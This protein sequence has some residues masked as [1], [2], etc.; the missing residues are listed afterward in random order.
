MQ[1]I[2]P[3]QVSPIKLPVG[4]TGTSEIKTQNNGACKLVISGTNTEGGFDIS[5][6]VK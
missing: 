3:G 5:W 4:I 2:D 1:I 6:V